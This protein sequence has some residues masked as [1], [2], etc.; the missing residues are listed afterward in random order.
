TRHVQRLLLRHGIEDREALTSLLGQ[1]RHKRVCLCPYCYGLI[2]VKEVEVPAPLTFTDDS[3]EG[4]GYRI[5]V[6]ENWLFPR[7]TI[8][9]PKG[10]IV[11]GREPAPFLTRNGALALLFAIVVPLAFLA[12]E[13]LTGQ[14]LPHPLAVF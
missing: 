14:H 13:L 5:E 12:T 2:P 9:G 7:L 10:E 11:A 4:A 3:L 8:A 1:A 6:T